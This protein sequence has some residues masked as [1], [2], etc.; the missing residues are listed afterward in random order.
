MYFRIHRSTLISIE[1]AKVSLAETKPVPKVLLLDHL[2]RNTEERASLFSRLS[3]GYVSELVLCMLQLGFFLA[4]VLYAD[5]FK[6][7]LT[8]KDF[9]P[10]CLRKMISD[11][12]PS[13][14][15]LQIA[16]RDKCKRT[17]EIFEKLLEEERQLKKEK[18]SLFRVTFRY[19]AWDLFIIA[20]QQ[21]VVRGSALAQPMVLQ[22]FLMWFANPFEERWKGFCW[23]FLF[24]AIPFVSSILE[25]ASGH[26]YSCSIHI[27]FPQ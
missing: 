27:D 21:I 22:H 9:W 23:A 20:L 18:A 4:L 3:F 24:F 13:S 1:L 11:T 7:T 16:K 19:F 10:V 6:N 17:G 15:S 14:L 5:G 25:A 12:C 2:G 8:K 26:R